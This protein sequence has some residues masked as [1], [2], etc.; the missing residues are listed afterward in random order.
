MK[1]QISKP[2]SYKD[3]IGKIPYGLTNDYMFH[4][5]LQKSTVAL[6]G[7]IASVLH[8]NPES[9]LDV[10]ITNPIKIGEKI[11][12]KTFVLDIIVL[13]NNDQLINLEM[14][15]ANENN[16]QD[17]SLSYACRSFDQLY[18]GEEYTEAKPVTHIGFLNFPP[19]PEAPEFNAIFKLLNVKN[20]HVYSDKFVFNVIDLTHIEL[21]TEEDKAYQIDYWALL[22]TATTWEDLKMIA[23]KN[24]YLE[25]ASQTMYELSSDEQVQLQCR[26]R[27]DYYKQINT[28]NRTLK[29][30]EEA[31]QKIEEYNKT[32]EQQDKT[33]EQKDKTIE[34]LQNRIKKLEAQQNQ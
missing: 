1:N 14:Q 18:Q 26:A 2:R 23:E 25:N 13:L 10:T 4:A 32:I 28:H 27:R 31:N 30:L 29:E 33:I 24:I 22:F 9:I 6:K 3:A 11:E 16:W 19:F 5:V 21:A 17:R 8:L 20:H 7:L 12:N 34:Q 15:V